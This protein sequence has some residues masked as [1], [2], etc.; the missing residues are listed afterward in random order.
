MSE[1]VRVMV[2]RGRKKRCVVSAF[3]WPGWDR[4]A[5]TEAEALAVLAAYRPR[6][7]K[8]AALAGFGKEFAATGDLEVVERLDGVGMTDFY[9]VSMKSA[10][11][12]YDRMS[13][14]VCER[15]IALLQ[16]SWAYF[17]DV[18]ARV[19]PELR[20][21]PRGG[22][23]DREQIVRHA[24]GAEIEEFAV[25]VGITTAPEVW[26]NV[27]EHREDLRAHR[28]AFCAALRDYNARGV[29]ARTWTVQFLIRHSAYH[30]LDHAW[31]MED[32]DLA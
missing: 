14:A 25:K 18:A 30:V 31:E 7:A 28:E 32:R 15:K 6:Y 12:E 24:N 27:R 2:E 11:P 3:D 10:R 8:I 19:S 20:E 23:R 29:P 9:G 5:K 4:N 21:G 17:D 13:D 22:G 26:Q 16:A 1:P